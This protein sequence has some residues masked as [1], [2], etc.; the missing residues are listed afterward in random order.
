M[1]KVKV[2]TVD[3]RNW[4]IKLDDV[5]WPRV[6]TQLT[7]SPAH[8]GGKRGIKELHNIIVH[9]ECLD[10]IGRG[11][12]NWNSLVFHVNKGSMQGKEFFPDNSFIS[13]SSVTY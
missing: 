13:P 2:L 6:W 11:R 9:R 1:I 5:S 10:G 8:R 7:K 4:Y 12:A 3:Y